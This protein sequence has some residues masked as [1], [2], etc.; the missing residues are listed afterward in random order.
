MR[1]LLGGVVALDLPTLLVSC[2]LVV[3]I[4]G[5]TFVVSTVLRHNDVASRL[6]SAAFTFGIL[7]MVSFAVWA[8][9]PH[10]PAIVGVG[11]GALTLAMGFIWSGNRAY[12]GRSPLFAVSLAGGFV[13]AVLAWV[14]ADS[15]S[16]A[17]GQVFLVGV[18]AYA[19]LAG[20]E[21]LSGRMRRD[22]NARILA[23]VM[24][25]V[26][27]FY[28]VR[29]VV[30][31]V[32]GPYS[33]VFLTY[34]D[35]DI[36]TFITI[37]FVITA[38]TAMS[39]LRIERTNARNPRAVD[40]GQWAGFASPELFG[41]AVDDRL[42]RLATLRENGVLIRISIDNLSE[43]NTA[44]GRSF[45]DAAMTLLGST[46][47]NEVPASAVLGHTGGAGF[48]ALVF[49]SLDHALD[50]AQRIRSA[51]IDTPVDVSQGLRVS[52]TIALVVAEPGGETF[53]SL[54]DRASQFIAEGQAAG[55]NV[56]VGHPEEFSRV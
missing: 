41:I 33:D 48:D 8:V 1:T 34:F 23:V 6:W 20:I 24:L 54:S 37:L 14:D 27:V 43:M 17:G 47:R 52:A 45:S 22:L 4:C 13:V 40:V 35:S 7:T 39:V 53:A 42:E 21:A 3:T 49:E 9:V 38:S 18:A 11:N 2:A 5:T 51:L 16:W 56:I 50:R 31:A 15:G 25:I 44:F 12:N 55:G 36:T 10:S 32:A 46:L 19:L 28:A 26:G 29:S 30:F